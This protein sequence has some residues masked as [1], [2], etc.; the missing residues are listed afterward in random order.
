MQHQ[1]TGSGGNNE[2]NDRGNWQYSGTKGAVRVKI[3]K[4]EKY[5]LRVL[6]HFFVVS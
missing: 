2:E 1:G 6:G 5:F 4:K 3:D